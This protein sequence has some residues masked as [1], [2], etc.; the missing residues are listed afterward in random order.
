[1]YVYNKKIEFLITYLC[2]VNK[3]S[4]YDRKYSYC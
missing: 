3:Y 4:N 1:M 2:N